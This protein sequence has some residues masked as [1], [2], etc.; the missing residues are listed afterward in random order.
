MRAT[1][2]R[3]Q[4]RS[5][6]GNAPP[7][8]LR[9]ARLRT[10]PDATGGAGVARGEPE[11]DGA[12][13]GR[14]RATSRRTGRSRGGSTPTRSTSSSSTTS[15]ERAGVR[16][17]SNMIGIGWAGP[18]IVHAGTEEQKERYLFPLLA[19]EEIWCQLFSEPGAGSDL[20]NLGTRAVRDGDEW[21][22]NGQK[23]WTS[24]GHSSRRSASSSPAPTPT[25]PSTRASRTSSARWTRRASRSGR[26]SR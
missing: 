5:C 8:G 6:A 9:A 22:V 18:T 17:P 1:L 26:S 25:P 10:I 4:A 12:P 24:L 3:S 11:P 20:A 2:I 23:I 7:H 16:R 19:G 14:G 15:C 21:V 13:A